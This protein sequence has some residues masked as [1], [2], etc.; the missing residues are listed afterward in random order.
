[1]KK[2]QSSKESYY[3]TTDH[4]WIRFQ[5]DEAYIGISHLKLFS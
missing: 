5:G 4:E 3:Y 2:M 1:M